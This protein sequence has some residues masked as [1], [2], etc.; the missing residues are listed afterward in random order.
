MKTKIIATIGPSTWHI[1]TVRKMVEYGMDLARINASFADKDELI[2]VKKI[3]HKVNPLISMMI[4]TIGF[5]IRLDK[6]NS[7]VTLKK[8]DVVR[9]SS[10]PTKD[11]ELGLDYKFL[12]K[13]VK[14]GER[15]FI[16]DGLVQLKITEVKTEYVEAKAL[17][18]CTIKKGKTFSLPD[19]QLSFNDPISEKDRINIQNAVE[20]GYDF[21]NISFVR[22]IQDIRAIRDFIGPAKISIIAKIEN[23]EGI[24]SIDEVLPYVDALMIPR[25]DLAVETPFENLPVIQKEMSLKAAHFGKPVIYASQILDSMKSSRFPL[26]AEISDLGNAVYDRVDAI[27]LAQETAI[28]SY[29]ATTVQT[30]RKILTRAESAFSL[31]PLFRDEFIMDTL[32]Q[33]AKNPKTKTTIEK[34]LQIDYQL[35]NGYKFNSPYGLDTYKTMQEFWYELEPLV[36]LSKLRKPLNIE[37]ES[38]DARAIRQVNLLYGV[39]GKLT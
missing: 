21:L 18:P 7:E 38:P 34:A 12:E 33:S 11:A 1:S 39:R 14:V 30:A 24:Q 16:D 20:V 6:T 36:Y 17:I 19:S 31:D 28:G 35:A 29:P 23:D 13:D 25:G 15:I 37:F 2:R 3:Y 10:N 27:M 9:F 4:D 22:N 8:G 26:K 32:E 5:K